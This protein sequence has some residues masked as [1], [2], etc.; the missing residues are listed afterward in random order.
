VLARSGILESTGAAV[1][2]ARE[3]KSTPESPQP[4][5]TPPRPLWK[6]WP[7]IA[8]VVAVLALTAWWMLR[9]TAAQ[10]EAQTA[11]VTV[12]AVRQGEFVKTLRL[13]GIT[14]AVQSHSVAAPRLAGP[15]TGSIVIT[16]LAAPGVAV[17]P[18]DLLVEFDRQAQIKNALDR[19]AE[20]RDLV[21]QIRKKQAE[22]AAARAQDRTELVQ[23][24]NAVQTA[25]LEIRKNEVV[26]QID[27]EKNQQN[28]LEAEARLEQLRQTLELKR[29]AATSEVRILEI[30]RD[31]ARSAME[32]AQR[33]TEKMAV[34]APIAGLVVR[35]S[36][37]KGGQMGEVQE[38]DE[39]RAGVPF[40][41]V[42][43]PSKM[44]VRARINQAD[45]P[46]L[47]A[48]QTVSIGLDAYPDLRFPG[49][50]EQVAAIGVT[51]GMN[52]KV[53]TFQLLLAIEG[54]DAKLMPD[55]SAAVDVQIERRENALTIP[56]DAI[57]EEQGK[58]FV[59]VKNGS[60]FDRKEVKLGSRS[61]T[62]V[63]VESGLEKDATV[64]RTAAAR[65]KDGA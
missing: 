28:L 39:V 33:N 34:K 14:E 30:Q 21:E 43:N 60:G 62:E 65:L 7:V 42:V 29:R 18:G 63:V 48:G 8:G 45:V 5:V 58:A 40:M 16:K 51:S 49:R 59:Y 61:D 50:V 26:S 22:A 11:G 55:L 10:S 37:W 9:R 46:Y 20:Y 35:N 13:H 64:L 53:R 4:P 24:E 23:A 15:G 47:R 54:A 1:Q 41:Q 56:R 57:E 27:A 3:R 31:R 44:Q 2:P 19:Q 52:Q 25:K 32:H 36:I 12:A 38:G 17:K 6:R